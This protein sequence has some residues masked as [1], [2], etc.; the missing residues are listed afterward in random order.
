MRLNAP[1][2]TANTPMIIKPRLNRMFG[3]D[4]KCFDVAI[5]HGFF[6]EFSAMAGI[7]N[8][9]RAVDAVL[10]AQP[11]AVQLSVGQ[12]KLLQSVPG[13]QKPALVLR[14]DVANV[15]GKTLPSYIFSKTISEAVKQAL[16]Y[17][18]ACL[19][20]AAARRRTPKSSNARWSS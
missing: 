13:K 9:K 19:S 12:A 14:T 11:D 2:K 6:N 4:G 7:E 5:D 3:A 18:A 10:H 15:Y 16:R 17:D 8:M 20:G 1:N